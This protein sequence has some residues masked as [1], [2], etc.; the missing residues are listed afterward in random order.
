MKKENDEVKGDTR[1]RISKKAFAKCLHE[2]LNK[3]RKVGPYGASMESIIEHLNNKVGDDLQDKKL[4]I[5]TVNRMFATLKKHHCDYR[6]DHSNSRY[7]LLDTSWR[8]PVELF[9]SYVD[10]I[11]LQIGWDILLK[12]VGAD[13]KGEKT[14]LEAMHKET[15]DKLEAS[16]YSEGV[17]NCEQNIIG[18]V[19]NEP[20][21]EKT[22]ID[23]SYAYMAQ[24]TVQLSLENDSGIYLVKRLVLETSGWVVYLAKYKG[25]EDLTDPG[26]PYEI[27]KI[28]D[29]NILSLKSR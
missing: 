17:F 19:E 14:R 26:K 16:E 15:R 23:L 27:S 28:S 7:S 8:M 18:N 9:L 13:S 25:E 10:Q 4:D 1:Q 21:D 11:A 5:D 20:L 29:T 22:F 24:Y 2:I 3:L 6:Y 12:S